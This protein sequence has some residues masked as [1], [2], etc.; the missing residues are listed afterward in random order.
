MMLRETAPVDMSMAATN[1]LAGIFTYSVAM[2]HGT[3]VWFGGW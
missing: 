1:L 3:G 2:V